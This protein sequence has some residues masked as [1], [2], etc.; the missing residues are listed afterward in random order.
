MTGPFSVSNQA[1]LSENFLW[2]STG[3]AKVDFF[4]Q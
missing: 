2:F 3:Q 4:E 1:I